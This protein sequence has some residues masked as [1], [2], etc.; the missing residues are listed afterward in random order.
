[1]PVGALIQG[2]SAEI[3]KLFSAPPPEQHVGEDEA[4]R[5]EDDDTPQDTAP[6][7]EEEEAQDMDDEDADAR[8]DFEV[9]TEDSESDEEYAYF[10]RHAREMYDYSTP[11]WR[12]TTVPPRVWPR[13]TV[14]PQTFDTGA[15]AFEYCRTR[16]AALREAYDVARRRRPDYVVKVELE[17]AV[18][19]ITG[20]EFSDGQVGYVL[21]G[22]LGKPMMAS[23][24]D[25]MLTLQ[26]SGADL[27]PFSR[28]PIR[29]VSAVHVFR[30]GGGAA[31]A[32][33][34]GAPAEP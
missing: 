34:M 29:T 25:K 24:I 3:A 21:D 19:P 14:L 11:S 6:T 27:S 20:E 9:D 7:Q 5:E 4:L 17:E 18:D 33:S 2:H 15:P 8:T 1:M 28:L 30:R 31:A 22:D 13:R 23:T 32:Q 12:P 16:A 26:V 10:L